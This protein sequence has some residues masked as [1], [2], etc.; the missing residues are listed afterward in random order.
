MELR[1]IRYAPIAAVHVAFPKPEEAVRGFGFL[2]PSEEKRRV[3]GAMFISSFFPF[4]TPDAQS[5]VTVMVGGARNPELVSKEEDELATTVR[6]ELGQTLKVRTEPAFTK[7][8][9]W[10][11]GIPQYEVGHLARMERIDAAVKTLKGLHLTGN[12][13]RG[14]G[15]LDC[16]RNA[17]A[18]AEAISPRP[19]GG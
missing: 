15:V 5:L 18:L 6:E 13:Y 19:A 2:V 1:A 9:R 16:V 14:V 7:V 11:R 10:T 17:R 3:L 12:A 8:V 4:R